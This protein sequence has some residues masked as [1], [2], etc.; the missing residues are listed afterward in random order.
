MPTVPVK[1][2]LVTGRLTAR[3][4]VFDKIR[5]SVVR[6]MTVLNELNDNDTSITC[7]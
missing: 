3:F 4:C 7:A 2:G 6:R 1:L 5:V